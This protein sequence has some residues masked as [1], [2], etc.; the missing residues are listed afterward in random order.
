M[1]LC[2]VLDQGAP[3]YIN[4]LAKQLSELP[5]EE[6][7]TVINILTECLYYVKSAK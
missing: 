5:P 2:D 4:D 3:A 7:K 1:L 6:R